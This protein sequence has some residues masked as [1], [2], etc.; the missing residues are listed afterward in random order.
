M[1]E[2]IKAPEI[3][4]KSWC[5]VLL[6]WHSTGGKIMPKKQI[7][8]TGFMGTGKSM[9]LNCLHE[10]CGFDKIEMDEQIVQEQGMSIP[11]IFA[12]KGE[13][14]FRNLETELVKRISHMDNIV[15]SCGGG[16]VMRQCNVE[17]MKKNGTIVLLTATPQTVYERVKGSHN[18]PLLEK[19]MNPQYIEQLM[20][21]RRPKYEAAADII[22]KTDGRTAKEICQ[23]IK[24]RLEINDN[25]K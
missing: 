18:R 1:S 10:V 3:F 13:E 22:V 2:G 25:T 8:L 7:Y 24:E 21:A 17:E 19:N 14:T 4:S 15:V 9:I 20:E 12:Q 5:T 6:S 11:D 16:T 23:E